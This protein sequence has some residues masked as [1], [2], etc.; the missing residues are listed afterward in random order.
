MVESP[1]AFVS[2]LLPI[3]NEEAFI[4]Q[5]LGAILSQDYPPE[6]ME[7]LIADGMSDD[8]TVHIIKAMPN[9]HR[10]RIIP[11]PRRIQAAGLNE[12]IRQARGEVL[13]RVDGHTIIASDYVRQ[14][15]LV[16]QETQASNVGGAMDPVGTTWLGR[17]IAAAG[18]SAFAV[19]T[20]F[21]VS[22]KPQLTDTVYLGAWPRRIFEEL[23]GYNEGVGVNE[24]YELNYR[25][26]AAGGLIYFTPA[27][28]SS[29][30]GRQTLRALAK[31]YYRYGRS[32]VKML[33]EHPRSVRLRHLAAPS[34]VAALIVGGLISVLVPAVSILWLG[35]ITL[36]ALCAIAASLLLA[37]QYGWELL[38]LLPIIFLTIHFAW[39]IGFW[40]ENIV[41]VALHPSSHAPEPNIPR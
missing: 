27:I 14:C 24:D 11:N 26:R 4:A 35:I 38:P 1:D 20:T 34:F 3:R 22:Q 2:V 40:V 31:Q 25:I 37:T 30:Y 32:K 23:G 41:P 29:Y 19:P 5:C 13:I 8:R 9:A 17:A 39:G 6:R 10:V 33:R 7:I 16:L 36:Y 21:H 12:L 15:V 28:R 18:K